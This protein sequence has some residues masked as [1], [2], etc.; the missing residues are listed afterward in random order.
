[1]APGDKRGYWT[2][3]KGRSTEL[4]GVGVIDEKYNLKH[5][6]NLRKCGPFTEVVKLERWSSYRGGQ[7]TEVVKL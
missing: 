3:I 2:E 4:R 5:S 1:M 6:N 7:V